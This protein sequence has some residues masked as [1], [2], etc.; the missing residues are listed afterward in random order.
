M[1]SQG[2]RAPDFTL[3]STNGELRL[4][5]LLRKG[6]VLLA[7]Y[8]EDGTPSC[9]TQLESLEDAHDALRAVGTQVI[10]VSADSIESHR[11]FSERCGGLPYP[12]ASDADLAVARAYDVVAEDDPRRSRRA[13]FVIERDGTASFAANPYS[14]NSV[15]QLEEVLRAAGV[16]M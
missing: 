11:A 10:G 8:V 15:S 4:T 12:L 14:P 5:D 2:E 13:L 16:E 7:F 1:V 6:R 3:A 9:A